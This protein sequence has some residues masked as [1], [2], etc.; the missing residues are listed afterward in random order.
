M[1]RLHR[2][3]DL[4]LVGAGRLLDDWSELRGL[5]FELPR[6]VGSARLVARADR[7]APPY[8]ALEL[9]EG[10]DPGGQRAVGLLVI[11]R[12]AGADAQPFDSYVYVDQPIRRLVPV[13]VS[14]HRPGASGPLAGL[15]GRPAVLNDRGEL[16]CRGRS[17]RKVEHVD[18]AYL[19]MRRTADGW[20][21]FVPVA[22]I[23]GLVE[24]PPG[25]SLE[26]AGPTGPTGPMGPMGPKAPAAPVERRAPAAPVEPKA[27][28]E[29]VE[30]VAV[31]EPVEPAKLAPAPAQ[32]DGGLPPTP[33]PPPLAVPPSRTVAPEEPE[34]DPD[35][36]F[37]DV[38]G[39]T[40]FVGRPAVPIVTFLLGCGLLVTSTQVGVFGL[41][42]G[43]GLMVAA[44]LYLHAA[45]RAA[46]EP[47]A[48]TDWLGRANQG[49]QSA[50]RQ[51]DD[52]PLL[53]AVLSI[54]YVS[55]LVTVTAFV[56]PVAAAVHYLRRGRT[57]AAIA[58]AA[59]IALWLLIL[60]LCAPLGG[61][62]SAGY[63]SSG[64]V[65]CGG[66]GGSG[67]GM[68]GCGGSGG[69][70]VDCLGGPGAGAGGGS[71]AGRGGG[72]ASTQR[73]STPRPPPR[74]S[75]RSTPRPVT[76][77]P[78]PSL[79][80][81]EASS[82]DPAEAV[83][84]Y[85]QHL[86]A[87]E[88]DDAFRFFG[89]SGWDEARWRRG[90]WSTAGCAHVNRASTLSRSG[91]NAK[92]S[93]DLCVEDTKQRE[94][95]RWTGTMGARLQPEGHWAMSSWSGLERSGTCRANCRP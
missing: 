59:G 22:A 53:G 82:L 18:Q 57:G 29:P 58:T 26:A 41:V 94:V 68:T 32:A 72:G 64:A 46:W 8:V 7:T 93:I 75:P 4:T 62:S 89:L 61:P 52:L 76:P 2:L 50:L 60:V 30:P 88:P 25:V 33:R 63:G 48:S 36:S 95:H 86:D 3:G 12:L 39:P 23:T 9:F 54:M 19:W 77:R 49:V 17:D 20:L 6:P 10:A 37:E 28:V 67:P 45:R 43:G 79:R 70:Q 40:R 38:E 15:V 83:T 47:S 74:S 55:F 16:D 56:A 51:L 73:A 14:P 91:S 81:R 24:P 1:A 44:A 69:E 35:L 78:T 21:E 5:T 66:R 34:P 65:D 80:E 11:H 13:F 31:F 87:R 84:R 85:Y 92:I 42:L 27:P 90:I 71:G